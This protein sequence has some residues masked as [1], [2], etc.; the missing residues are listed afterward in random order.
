MTLLLRGGPFPPLLFPP[1][2]LMY[3]ILERH[4]QPTF[5]YAHKK[6]SLGKAEKQR[7]LAFFLPSFVSPPSS[8]GSDLLLL[9]PSS[10]SRLSRAA[11][12]SYS[13]GGT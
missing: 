6:R 1:I 2:F 4:T 3:V 9:L 7:F 12:L 13:G 11:L 8:L 5:A 10:L